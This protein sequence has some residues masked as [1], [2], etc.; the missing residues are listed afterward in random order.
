MDNYDFCW[1][2]L[3]LIEIYNLIVG[4]IGVGY[5]GG[6]IVCLYS[7]L[8]VNVL[9]IDLVYYVELEVDLIYVDFEILF[10]EVDIVIIYIFFNEEMVNF[11][12]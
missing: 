11:L 1:V 5:I 9:V 3:E 7:V 2:G 8:G 10:W 12:D 6:V 4:V